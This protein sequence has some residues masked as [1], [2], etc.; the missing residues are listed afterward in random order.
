MDFLKKTNK[1]PGVLPQKMK[2]EDNSLI[3]ILSEDNFQFLVVSLVQK[4]PTKRSINLIWYTGRTLE[5]VVSVLNL[6]LGYFPS[7]N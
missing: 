4:K 2:S 5:R 3:F 6:C 7:I 1:S